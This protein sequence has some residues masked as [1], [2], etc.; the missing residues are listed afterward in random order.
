MQ[1]KTRDRS[2]RTARRRHRRDRETEGH[3]HRRH[4]GRQDRADLLS[5]GAHSR[6]F[7]H[8]CDR[9]EDARRRGP[10]RPGDSQ[11]SGRGPGAAFFARSADQGISAG[12]SGQQHIEVVVAKLRKRYHVDLALHPPK[13]PYRETIRGKADAEGKHKKQTGGHGQFGVCRIRM[14]PL[15]RGAGFEFV[16]DIFGG[17][18]PQEL[19]SVGRKRN[20]RRRPS[21][22]TWRDFRWWI[23]A[24]S[25][26][27]ANITTWTF[28]TWRSRSPARSRSRKRMKQA[29]PALL[30]PVMHVEVYAPDQYSGDIMG[31]LSS[32]RG[33]D[34]RKR[35]ARRERGGQGA[36]AVCRNA[37]LRER[38]DV[39]DAGARKLLD[40]IFTLR[41]RAERNCGESDCAAKA[42]KG[43]AVE[44]EEQV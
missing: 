33:T 14:E 23:S 27:T 31:D 26:T 40:G 44:E 35:S 16:D 37:E 17:A 7:D 21:A 12:G 24:R 28:A 22:A 34:Q 36:G 1:G 9:A 2:G 10:H 6:A 25:S 5:A 32:R 29:R 15:P 11:N 39:H 8:V 30:E 3:A 42:A 19:D 18:I 20:S 13:V 43:V 38:A 41:L 4:A